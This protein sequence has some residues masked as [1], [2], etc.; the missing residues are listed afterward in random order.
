MRSTSAPERPVKRPHRR[1]DAS[2]VSLAADAVQG[3]HEHAHG[4][5]SSE[6]DPL[7]ARYRALVEQI[8]AITYTQVDDPDSPTGFRDIY[9]SPQTF[10]ILGYTPEEWQ[11]HPQRSVRP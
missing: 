10:D 5:D 1:A 6:S 7:A 11:G 3:G 9:I 2:T 8:P 4:D